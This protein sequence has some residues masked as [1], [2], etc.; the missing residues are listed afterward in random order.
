MLR[1]RKLPAN[2]L[3]LI[4]ELDDLFPPKCIGIGEKL[5]DAHRYAGKRDVIEFLQK[6]VAESTPASPLEKILR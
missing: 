1:E 2:S 4:K 5:D 3:D 6:L